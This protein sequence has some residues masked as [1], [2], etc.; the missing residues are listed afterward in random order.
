MV[1]MEGLEPSK[2]AVLSGVDV[3]FSI[4]PHER[5]VILGSEEPHG[6]GSGVYGRLLLRAQAEQR[7]CAI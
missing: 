7:G 4:M 6:L 2:L 3:P 1:L 5:K